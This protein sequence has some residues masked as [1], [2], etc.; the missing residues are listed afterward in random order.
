MCIKSARSE[1]KHQAD[2]NEVL[3]LYYTD[4]AGTDG[5]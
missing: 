3:T 4:S 1:F 2:I 5:L